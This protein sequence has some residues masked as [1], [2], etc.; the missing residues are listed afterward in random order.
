LRLLLDEHLSPAIAEQLRARGQDVVTVVEAGL[1]GMTD[2]RVLAW[3]VREGRA[4]VTNN[5]RDFRVL[6][7]D[8]LKTRS[9]HCG[10]VLVPTGKYSLRRDQSGPLVGALDRLL[11]RS[12]S[13]AGLEDVEYFL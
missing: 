8:S 1:A 2:E 12:P 3:A 6:H 11:T 4:V 9:R 7:A 10:I 5:I 13:T